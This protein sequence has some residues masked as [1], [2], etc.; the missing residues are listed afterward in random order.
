MDDLDHQKTEDIS[1]HCVES[2]GVMP[3]MSYNYPCPS[4]TSPETT[5]KRV[6]TN[7]SAENCSSSG[8]S[9]WHTTACICQHRFV[10]VP[11]VRNK[12]PGLWVWLIQICIAGLFS[13]LKTWSM[14]VAFETSLVLD[15]HHSCPTLKMTL[16]RTLSYSWPQGT[17][18]DGPRK[19]KRSGYQ[20]RM[21]TLW[22]GCSL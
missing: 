6:M 5:K 9:H 4:H 7:P 18:N 21:K 19:T 16:A 15:L 12:M 11:N 20:T 1:F 22:L 8:S 14:Q 17:W 13:Q 2:N 10:H 3:V